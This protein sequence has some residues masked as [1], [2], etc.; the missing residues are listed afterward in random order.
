MIADWYGNVTTSCACSP[1][2]ITKLSI[3]FA[4]VLYTILIFSS[5]IILVYVDSGGNKPAG[6]INCPLVVL[7]TSLCGG[8]RGRVLKSTI[9]DDKLYVE[10]NICKVWFV[11]GLR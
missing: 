2:W 9:S 5:A 8:D 1:K 6:I 7:V 11:L 3:G 10:S 4:D